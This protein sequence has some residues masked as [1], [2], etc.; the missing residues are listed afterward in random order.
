ML[1]VHVFTGYCGNRGPGRGATVAGG[2][3][4]DV[5]PT[6]SGDTRVVV[7]GISVST[8]PRAATRDI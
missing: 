6:E 5:G 3:H 1:H 2:T 4:R 7:R 8:R